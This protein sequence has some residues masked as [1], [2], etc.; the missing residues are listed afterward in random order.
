MKAI[1]TFSILFIAGACLLGQ[2]PEKMSYQAVVRDA[3]GILLSNS[4]VGMQISILQGSAQGSPVYIETQTPTSN[5][6][7]LISIEIGT[8]TSVSGTF[9]EIDWSAGPFF[10]KSETDPTGG[11]NYTI[12]GTSQ[13]LSVPYALFAETAGHVDFTELDPVFSASPS[14]SITGDDVTGWN[15]KLEMEVDGSV[16]NEIQTISRSGST[17]TLSDGGG[18]FKDSVN[19]YTPGEGIVIEDF[20]ISLKKGHY[21]GELYMGGIIFYIDHTGEHGLVVSLTDLDGGAGVMWSDVVD[22][23]IGDAAMSATDG[24]SNTDA[25]IAQQIST[26]TAQLC[27]NLGAEWY[28]P[29]NRELYLLFSHEILIDQILDND[30]DP[31]TQGLV[32]ERTGPTEG[33]YWSST[34]QDEKHAW[35]YKA[36]SGDTSSFRKSDKCRVRAVRAF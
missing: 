26:S 27:R 19:T 11:S 9:G 8:G 24:A 18:S 1:T 13:I 35:A 29:S 5:D 7:G 28:L 32:Q 2:V 3:S 6:N 15:N 14:S 30:E 4:S 33:K 23:E 10:I 22:Q 17:V 25:I 36:D 12:S 31:A 16:T 20:S 34:E 21:I